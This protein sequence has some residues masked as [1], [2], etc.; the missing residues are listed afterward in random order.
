MAEVILVHQ[1]WVKRYRVMYAWYKRTMCDATFS[2]QVM[3]VVNQQSWTHTMETV[4]QQMPENG[5]ALHNHWEFSCEVHSK[6]C[7]AF[8]S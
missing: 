7:L 2:S 8:Q 6:I 3:L 1:Q 4:I 5:D